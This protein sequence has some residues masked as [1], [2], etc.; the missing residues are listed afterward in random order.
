MKKKN[1]LFIVIGILLLASVI[2][3][4]AGTTITINDKQV[5]SIGGFIAAYLALVIIAVMLV[6]IIPSVFILA[7][8]LSIIFVVFIGLFFPLMPMA[9]LLLPAIILAGIFYLVYRLGK[10]KKILG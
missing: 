1:I 8:V 7:L 4:F 10:K 2:H 9:F 5:T 3:F 6:I